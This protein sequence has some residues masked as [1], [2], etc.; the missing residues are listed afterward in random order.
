MKSKEIGILRRPSFEQA[1]N[2][3]MFLRSLD[4]LLY[5]LDVINCIPTSLSW[6]CH[7]RANCVDEPV[8]SF[9]CT[10]RDG[11]TGDGFDCGGKKRCISHLFQHILMLA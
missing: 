1:A 8:G 3:I 9:T 4:N 7:A 5:S 11:F 2:K 10:C 6:P